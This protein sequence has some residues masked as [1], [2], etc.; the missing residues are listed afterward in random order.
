M[1]P[2]GAV[3][4]P[5]ESLSLQIFEPRYVALVRD[6]TDGRRE[7]EFGVVLIARGHEVGGGEV[8]TQ[9]GTVARI[10][11]VIELPGERYRLRCKG[12]DR[13]RIEKWLADAPYPQAEAETWP[14]DPGTDDSALL[15][16]LRERADR[17]HTLTA[18][19]A[20]RNGIRRPPPSASLDDLSDDPTTRSYELA[21]R[22]PIGPTDRQAALSAPNAHGRLAALS[23]SV[24][25][26]IAMMEFR[27]L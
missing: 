23:A 25:D 7:P 26:A 13:I 19:F 10:T 18:Q 17:L 24:D 22:L 9:V 11:E 16:G 15:A 8:R 4:L 20:R 14:D 6:C 3:L 5:G 1:F 12:T 27:L 2:L 21:A